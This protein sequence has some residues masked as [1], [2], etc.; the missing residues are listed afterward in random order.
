[1]LY[2]PVETLKIGTKLPTDLFFFHT[3]KVAVLKKGHVITQNLIDKIKNH[4]IAGVYI[5][6]PDVKYPKPE[7]LVN[8]ELKKKALDVLKETFED[9]EFVPVEN[10]V[11]VADELVDTITSNKNVFVNI[12]DL[13]SYDD[14]TFHHSISVAVI[15]VAIGRQ[16]ELKSDVLRQLALC[17]LLHDIGKIEVPKVLINKPAKLTK[18]EYEE[19][20]K[21]VLR[22]IEYLNDHHIDIALIQSGVAT[23]HE[24]Y[25]GQGY[26]RQLTGEHIPLFGRIIAIADVFDALTSKRPYREP[27]APADAA[28]YIMGNSGVAFD[29]ELVKVFMQTMEFYPPGTVVQLSTGQTAIVLHSEHPLRPVVRLT[30]RPYKKLDLFKDPKN[31]SITITAAFQKVAEDSFG[32]LG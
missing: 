7:P 10:L 15:S 17:S 26:P 3:D 23:H 6:E 16:M 1:M 5:K 21:H 29:H 30:E 19:V 20:Q 14:Y 24:R 25:D 32:A 9:H 28:E 11:S 4:E 31:L 12:M 2:V 22:G 18:E 13:K 8:P 27:M